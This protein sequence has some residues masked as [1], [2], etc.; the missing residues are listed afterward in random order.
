MSKAP[1]GFTG[2]LDRDVQSKIDSSHD[3]H[4]ETEVRHWIEGVIG[5]KFPSPNFETSLKNGVILCKLINR[6][7]PGSVPKIGTGSAPF[8]QMENINNFLTSCKALGMATVDLFMTVDLF[9]GKNLG[10]VIRSLEQLRRLAAKHGVSTA[11]V[12]DHAKP[13]GVFDYV[14]EKEVEASGVG[15]YSHSSSGSSTHSSSS[16]G[17]CKSCSKS[18]EPSARFCNHCGAKV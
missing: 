4:Q 13:A 10:L 3:P 16:K 15:S 11:P 6:I 17:Q 8:V 9:E 12:I 1:K 2:G 7:R 18:L 14:S 5:E